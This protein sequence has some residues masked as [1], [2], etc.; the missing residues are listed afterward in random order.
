MRRSSRIV[1]LVLA[2]TVTVSALSAC[3]LFS[4]KDDGINRYEVT[5][6]EPTE[7]EQVVNVTAAVSVSYYLTARAYLDELLA[8]DTSDMSEEEFEEFSALLDNA[9]YMFD[10]SEKLSY[11]L[12]AAD[13][14]PNSGLRISWIP[15]I[16]LL[17]FRASRLLPTSLEQTQSMPMRSSSRLWQSLKVRSIPR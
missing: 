3:S 5:I 15:T 17:R 14:L 6:P 4:K 10:C 8:Y 12:T 2:A 11:E 9:I 13:L 16:R 1:S 7:A